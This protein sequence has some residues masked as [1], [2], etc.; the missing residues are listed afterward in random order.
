MTHTVGNKSTTKQ[1]RNIELWQTITS[2]SNLI[3]INNFD[4]KKVFDIMWAK[5]ATKDYEK[6]YFLIDYNKKYKTFM[7]TDL[8]K[9]V[10]LRDVTMGALNDL[11]NQGWKMT[12]NTFLKNKRY[13]SMLE[14]HTKGRN[15]YVENKKFEWTW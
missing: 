5:D 8:D 7:L 1:L 14:N 4:I 3:C 9:Y 11:Y 6:Y 10:V 15:K 12:F 2:K 13:K